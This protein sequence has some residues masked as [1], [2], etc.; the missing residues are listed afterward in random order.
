MTEYTHAV[1][2]T[3][4]YYKTYHKFNVKFNIKTNFD[5]IFSFAVHSDYFSFYYQI[6]TNDVKLSWHGWFSGLSRPSINPMIVIQ[7]YS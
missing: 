4:K 7:I 3:N 5:S 2:H 6:S 1:A